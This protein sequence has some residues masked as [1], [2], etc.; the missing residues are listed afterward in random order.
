M[1]AGAAGRAVVPDLIGMQ[2]LDAWLVGF[3]CGVLV[4]GPDPDS[5]E[6]VLHGIVV[7]HEP[8][9]GNVLARWDVVTVWVRDDPRHGGVREPRQPL[10]KALGGAADLEYHEA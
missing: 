5:P 6:P 4:E 9:V 2:A 3:D 7:A 10:P 1:D 8:K